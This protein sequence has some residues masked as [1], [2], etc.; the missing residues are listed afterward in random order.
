M[1]YLFVRAVQCMYQC[2]LSAY[3]YWEYYYCKIHA[4]IYHTRSSPDGKVRKREEK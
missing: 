2:W 3:Y 4:F 1:V